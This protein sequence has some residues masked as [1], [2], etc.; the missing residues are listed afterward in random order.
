MIATNCNRND[1]AARVL[2]IQSLVQQKTI[3]TTHVECSM[4]GQ[5][6]MNHYGVDPLPLPPHAHTVKLTHAW[7]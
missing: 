1:H 2:K 4:F 7:A 3:A 5:V 6:A